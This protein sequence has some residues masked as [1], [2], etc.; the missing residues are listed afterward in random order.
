MNEYGDKIVNLKAVK[1]D[2]IDLFDE[3]TRKTVI[4]IANKARREQNDE[5]ANTLTQ[6]LQK[7]RHIDANI[8]KTN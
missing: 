6:C 1:K 3:Y 5:V 7:S 4:D 8:C 2:D